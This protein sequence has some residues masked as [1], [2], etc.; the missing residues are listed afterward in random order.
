MKL[1]KI[2][3]ALLASVWLCATPVMAEQV[4]LSGLPDAVIEAVKVAD[5][6]TG[7]FIPAAGWEDMSVDLNAVHTAAQSKEA[8]RTL[9]RRLPDETRVIRLNRDGTAE[10][11]LPK[12][13]W[14]MVPDSGRMEPFLLN[15]TQDLDVVCKTAPE[16]VY[17]P[18]AV[19]TGVA[20]SAAVMALSAGLI[21][22]ILYLK[23]KA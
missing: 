14:L 5:N 22:W 15:V 2:I 20:V 1:L 11:S 10:E 7:E 16:Q 9:A 8:A 18:T 21:G 6:D 13:V 19:Q 12:G 4:R 17:V 23:K 3:G